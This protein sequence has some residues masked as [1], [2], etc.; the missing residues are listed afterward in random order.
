MQLFL[1]WHFRLL[2]LLT[3]FSES[4]MKEKRRSTS[5]IANDQNEQLYNAERK[6]IHSVDYTSDGLF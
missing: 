4:L 1:S 6:A 2:Y 5:E 3:D